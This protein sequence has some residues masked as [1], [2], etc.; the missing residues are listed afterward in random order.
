MITR[1]APRYH[2]DRGARYVVTVRDESG[3]R[4]EYRVDGYQ[5]WIAGPEGVRH[6]F[7]AARRSRTELPD[8]RITATVGPL[9]G[10]PG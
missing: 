10:R 8:A 9:T 2:F 7:G 1:A 5:G 4:R 6:R 3:T